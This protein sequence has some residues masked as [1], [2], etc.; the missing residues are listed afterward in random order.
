MCYKPPE[1]HVMTENIKATKE[2]RHSAVSAMQLQSHQ[3]AQKT[4]SEIASTTQK[5]VAAKRR[6]RPSNTSATMRIPHELRAQVAA[7]VTTYR[8]QHRDDPD[9]W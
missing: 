2:R 6:H 8:R 1:K 7:I 9:R 3:S 4:Q 5:T